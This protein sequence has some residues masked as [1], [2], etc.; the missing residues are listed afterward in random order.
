MALWECS[1]CGGIREARCKPKKC[2]ECGEK[3]TFVKKTGE[4]ETATAKKAAGKAGK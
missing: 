3:E 4:I 2:Q 1:A